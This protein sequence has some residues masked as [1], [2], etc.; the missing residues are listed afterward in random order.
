MPYR[1]LERLR[2]VLRGDALHAHAG[3][4]P[5]HAVASSEWMRGVISGQVMQEQGHDAPH[6][7]MRIRTGHN[8]GGVWCGAA[9]PSA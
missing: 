7:I 4:T 1:G 2:G 6:V 5:G 8:P 9:A 3:H